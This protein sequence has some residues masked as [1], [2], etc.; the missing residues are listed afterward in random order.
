MEYELYIDVFFLTNFLMD[1]LMLLLV[2]R[3]L[4]C[5]ATH[6]N[7]FQGALAGSAVSC[8]VVCSPLPAFVKL[9]CLHTLV[10]TGM[11]VIGL[12]IRTPGV[13]LKAYL[14][15]YLSGF[16][17][18]GVMSSFSQ[19]T[20]KYFRIGVLFFALTACSYFAASKGMTFLEMLWKIREY[21]CEVTVYLSGN[22]MKMRA[23]IDSGNTLVDAITGKPVHIISKKAIEKLTGKDFLSDFAENGM[24]IGHENR[25]GVRFIPYHTI[26][27]K[28]GVL[29]VI[30]IDKMCIHCSRNTGGE[31]KIIMSP[32]LGI[33]EQN[34]FGDG[35]FEII[36]HP[37]D[38]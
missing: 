35:T 12:R 30:T 32:L 18:G 6:G 2:R 16:L 3:A 27:E 29:P 7:I 23:M 13:F 5:T 31:E 14:L 4:S 15:L 17:M 38:C 36:L 8:V 11:V 28:E 22:S 25:R 33:S 1:Y 10:N 24:K 26:Q 9:I 21:R 19:Y 20:G 34:Q 37:E